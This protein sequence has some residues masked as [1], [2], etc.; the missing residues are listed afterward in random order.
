MIDCLIVGGGII[1]LAI[2][3]ELARAGRNVTVV[4]FNPFPKT[5]GESGPRTASLAS[6]GILPPPATRAKYDPLENIRSLSNDIFADWAEQLQADT[7]VDVDYKMC[8]GIQLAQSVGESIAL[9]AAVDEWNRDGV[10]VEE[11]TIQSAEQREPLVD[12]S[13]VQKAYRLKG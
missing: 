13:D 4:D 7:N 3:D 11:M 12:F 10:D 8:G 9:Q 2:G 5:T 1:G 6:A